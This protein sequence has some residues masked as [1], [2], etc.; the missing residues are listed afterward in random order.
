MAAAASRFA[1]ST[2][3]PA[4]CSPQSGNPSTVAS[5]D[6]SPAGE[7]PCPGGNCMVPGKCFAAGTLIWTATGLQPI[8]TIAVGTQVLSRDDESERTEWKPVTQ[9]FVNTSRSLVRL[10]V[11]DERGS[12]ETVWVTPNHRLNVRHGG[13]EATSELVPGRDE[14]TSAG[15]RPLVVLSAQSLDEQ[16]PVYNF[17]VADFHTYFVGEHGLW[18]HNRGDLPD[19]LAPLS[20][21][22]DP[23]VLNGLY[24]ALFD[25]R[26]SPGVF[27]SNAYASVLSDPA[28]KDFSS[29]AITING[30]DL[31]EINDTTQSHQQGDAYLAALGT[32]INN[33][34]H[35]AGG[36][37]FRVGGDK[38]VVYFPGQ[39]PDPK[40]V[41]QSIADELTKI[42]PH[43]PH[44]PPPRNP[45]VV[46]GLPPP[47]ETRPPLKFPGPE[48]ENGLPPQQAYDEIRAQHPEFVPLV[49]DAILK[50]P[51]IPG[52]YNK[53]ALQFWNPQG[54]SQHGFVAVDING[55]GKINSQHGFDTGTAAINAV[56]G[57]IFNAAASTG[58]QPF[59]L[60]GDE[61]A[62]FGP[63]P[64][65]TAQA[66]QDE[67]GKLP[68]IENNVV[69]SV[70]V[71]TGQTLPQAD[72]E[73]LNNKPQKQ[74]APDGC[75]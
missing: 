39:P 17:T 35:G 16:G 38:Y 19:P 62:T 34:V 14:L 27:N 24:R 69:P 13:W 52:L 29:H 63:N 46:N 75:G 60:S 49:N 33:A 3:L 54:D 59:H 56:G 32:A 28:M 40:A 71:G 23:A 74:P 15:D 67:V 51:N 10:T 53:T 66:I 68:P 9:T 31:K 26:Y 55:L 44:G 2:S 4:E 21:S 25:D 7:A 73:S 18:A 37:V 42:Y 70:S 8:E 22:I 11:T 65:A 12:E 6:P 1:D 47:K 50:D 48:I 45:E 30:G 41:Q 72:A 36:M 57:A 43:K 61:F 5:N 58:A 64:A 20:G